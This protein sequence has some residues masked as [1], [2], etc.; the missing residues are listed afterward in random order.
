VPRLAARLDKTFGR[1][2][3]KLIGY[4]EYYVVKYRTAEGG[5]VNPQWHAATLLEGEFRVPAIEKLF[6]GADVATGWTWFYGVDSPNAGPTSADTQFSHQPV[7]QSYGA[8]I[9]A[10]YEFP[11]FE[12]MNS[13]ISLAY[14]QGDPTL[15]YTS[16]LHDGARHM[17]FGFNRHVS[18]VYLT[19][20]ARY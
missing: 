16:V 9:F 11:T 6:I 10:R 18:E 4:G 12:G 8:E 17:Y 20:S 3:A 13:D 15:G 5:N 1:F 2:S 14:G 7:Q 19:L